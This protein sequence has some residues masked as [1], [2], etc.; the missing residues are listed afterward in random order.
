[1]VNR[2]PGEK[3]NDRLRFAAV[4]RVP[5]FF[6]NVCLAARSRIGRCE[7]FRA[8]ILMLGRESLVGEVGGVRVL[9]RHAVIIS[10][11]W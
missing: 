6:S 9:S 2:H 11:Q 5:R 10:E 1:M 4:G 7:V 8:G 3:R